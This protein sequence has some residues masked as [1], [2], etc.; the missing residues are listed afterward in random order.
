M[1][2]TTDRPNTDLSAAVDQALTMADKQ[3]AARFLTAQGAS[4]ALICRVMA[5][6]QRRRAHALDFPPA[7]S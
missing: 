3:A 6:P 1:T 7:A 4:F 2:T 5:E